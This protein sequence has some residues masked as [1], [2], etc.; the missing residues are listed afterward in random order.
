MDRRHL[1]LEC[2]QQARVA[3]TRLVLQD[4]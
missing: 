2:F 1:K 4:V 3:Q